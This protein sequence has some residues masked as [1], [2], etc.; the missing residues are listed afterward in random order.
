[1]ADSWTSWL[2]I[3]AVVALAVGPVM[4]FQPSAG[5]KRLAQFRAKAN[6]SGLNVML[7]SKAI[8]ELEGTACYSLP[9]I[10][11]SLRK[12]Q[13]QLVR[14]SYQHELH[15]NGFWAWLPD[16]IHRK[17]EAVL[18]AQLEQISANVVSV[19]ASPAGLG[20][21]WNEKGDMAEFESILV[22]LAQTQKRL[23][24]A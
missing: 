15:L 10:D 9:W 18:K 17:G 19:V 14:K 21:Y 2:I 8:P 12:N 7:A 5:Q 23:L 20:V 1:M 3:I 24:A 11:Q 13:W 16:N 22:W 4:M 6:Q